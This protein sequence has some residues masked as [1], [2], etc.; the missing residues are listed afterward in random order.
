MA[1]RDLSRH[2]E[3]IVKR[4][5]EH[6]ETIQAN[7]L[8]ELL[9]E[10]WLAESDAARNR[11]WKRARQAL[12]RLGVKEERVAAVCDAQDAEALGKLIKQ[13]ERGG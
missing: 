4:Y 2:Q 5:Y 3:K 8:G 9:S 11:L 1:Q 6:H 13:V 10:L 12:L 7:K